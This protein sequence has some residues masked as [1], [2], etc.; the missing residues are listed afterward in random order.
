MSVKIL[1]V[2]DEIIVAMDIKHRLETMGYNVLAAVSSGETAVEKA[3]ELKPDLILMDIVLKGQIDGIDA[4][5]LIKEN[6]NIPVIYLTAYSDEKT[7][8]RAKTTSPYGYIIKPFEDRELKCAI[9]VAL[10]KHEMEC[11]LKI[12]EEKY[13]YLFEELTDAIFITFNDYK[14]QDFNPSMLEL[15]G[16]NAEEMEN[17]SLF[18][19]FANSGEFEKFKDEINE[20]EQLKNYEIKFLDKEKNEIYCTAA[21][22]LR[23]S[24]NGSILGYYGFLHDV[25]EH[26]KALYALR[27]SEDK[28]RKMVGNLTDECKDVV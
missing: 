17:Q 26:K 16:Y 23:K 9:E 10:Y 8:N 13:R 20:K 27:R 14:F 21:V 1:V 3:G 25:T 2:E 12:N 15:F 6:Y 11:K 4:Y 18:D 5:N 24:D 7:L 19:L 28:Y 22:S